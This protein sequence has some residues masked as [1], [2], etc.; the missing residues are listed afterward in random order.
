M[1]AA[2]ALTCVLAHIR[3]DTD[4]LRCRRPHRLEYIDVLHQKTRA[5][6]IG[7]LAAALAASLTALGA[8]AGG[9]QATAQNPYER[10][11]APTTQTISA[12]RGPFATTEVAAPRGSGFASGRVYYP[13]ATDQG[14]FGAVVIVPGFLSYWSSMAWLGPRI[15][16]QGFVVMGIDTITTLDQPGQRSAQQL[17]ALSALLNDRRVSARIDRSRIAL[18]GWSM[19]G[20]GSLESAV[21]RPATKAVVAFTPWDTGRFGRLRT[22]TLIIG[23]QNDLVAPT[24]QHSI[25]HYNSIPAGV[26]KAY[27]ELAGEDHFYTQS[28]NTRQAAATIAWLKRFL[29]DDIR[30][31]QFIC[32]G[33]R[34][35][36]DISAYRS[37]CPI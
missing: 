29:D 16:S 32:P 1:I 33:P 36:G 17:A 3:G 24:G 10:G 35:G 31:S 2:I 23:A 13:T 5:R 37:T 4:S 18:A 21:S 12:T 22:P 7:G 26:E 15:A 19:G 9:A 30:Y 34:R 28:P 11:P 20:G 25:P 14:T 27:L 8:L 6:R